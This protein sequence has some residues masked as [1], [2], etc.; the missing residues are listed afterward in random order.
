M[1]RR[2]PNRHDFRGQHRSQN[3][4][5]LREALQHLRWEDRHKAIWIDAL[6]LNQDDKKEMGKQVQIMDRIYKEAERVL[7]WLGM[8]MDGSDR[9][10]DTIARFRDYEHWAKDTTTTDKQVLHYIDR[11]FPDRH[12]LSGRMTEVFSLAERPYWGRVWIVQEFHL[13]QDATIYC[14][15]QS[16]TL[17]I[18]ANFCAMINRL[19]KAF[20]AIGSGIP[21]I[22]E[23]ME[24]SR[25]DFEEVRHSK[26]A[27]HCTL[28][29]DR[30]TNDC[31]M[32][33]GNL[34]WKLN[35]S[36]FRCKSP[37]DY[38]YALRGIASDV[39]DGDIQC[40]YEKDIKDVYHDLLNLLLAKMS[41][42]IPLLGPSDLEFSLCRKMGVS[43]DS[44]HKELIEQY[45]LQQHIQ[46]TKQS[47][48]L[49]R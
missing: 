18:L 10:I 32:T 34:L 9:A 26:M 49:T 25:M 21:L 6:C 48:S 23:E 17:N 11:L 14:G 39:D 15:Q 42:S 45:G 16:I 29:T 7:V 30:T 37:R 40:D 27:W 20:H 22:A 19:G 3:S 36:D 4:S 47:L 35:Y 46:D 1:G 24:I 13:A 28:R 43:L 8:G 44:G 5:N 41:T 12:D 38:L 2:C 33:L 31:M